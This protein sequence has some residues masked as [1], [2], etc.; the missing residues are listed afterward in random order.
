M[1]YAYV[2][3]LISRSI[4]NNLQKARSWLYIKYMRNIQNTLVVVDMQD[5][6]I[7]YHPDASSEFQSLREMLIDGIQARVRE[8]LGSG[9]RVMTL[10]YRDS[11][12]IPE[13]EGVFSDMRVQ[14]FRKKKAGLF[15][16]HQES[17]HMFSPLPAGDAEIV[18]VDATECVLA[19]YRDIRTL[20][21]Q[22]WKDPNGAYVNGNLILD[23]SC[24]DRWY[25]VTENN[26]PEAIQRAYMLEDLPPPRY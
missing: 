12:I 6:Y 18:W 22:T 11:L 26:H 25:R 5:D 14:F 17:L 4:E 8:V 24:Y 15:P 19:V 21:V 23:T 7:G 10:T 3:A 2:Y 16:A 13:L 1:Y 20:Y 9:G